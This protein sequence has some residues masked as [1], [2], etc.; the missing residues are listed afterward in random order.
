MRRRTTLAEV[1]DLLTDTRSDDVRTRVDALRALCPCVV[2]RDDKRIWDRVLEM[3]SDPSE[4]VRRHVFH[5][6]GDG[7]PRDRECEVIAAIERLQ[8]DSDERLR[9][10]ARKLLAH[11][12][13]SGEIN[14]L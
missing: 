13:R 14:V 6:L 3:V 1:D 11:Y 2:K 10:R 5:L 7:S 9:R 12:R 8:F 4:K